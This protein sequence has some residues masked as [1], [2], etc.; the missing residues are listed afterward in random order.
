MTDAKTAEETVKSFSSALMQRGDIDGAL[1]YAHDDF[2]LREAPGLP[3]GGVHVGR[4][5]LLK[6][7][8]EIGGLF[9]FLSAFDVTYYGVNDS[10]VITKI[11]GSARVKATGQDVDWLVSEW[12]TVRDSKVVDIQMWYWDQAPVLEAAR[13]EGVPATG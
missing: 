6:L 2:T 1:T 3:Y 12:Y 9:E 5:G 13:A 10:L 7:M 4:E 11:T 8:E